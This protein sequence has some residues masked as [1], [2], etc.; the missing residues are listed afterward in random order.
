MHPI[1]RSAARHRTPAPLL[2]IASA[3]IML[4]V[5]CLVAA[6]PAQARTAAPAACSGTNAAQNRPATASSTEAA[7]TPASAAVDGSTGTRWS[8]AFADPQWLQ[9]DL[10]SSQQICQVTL[11]WEAAYATAFQIQVSATGTG[12]WTTTALP[13]ASAPAAL[14]AYS[15]TG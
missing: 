14:C 12:G 8:S 2:L 10:G 5:G 9:V 11:T 6:V 13:A 1:L 15:S 4:L 7:G 3:A